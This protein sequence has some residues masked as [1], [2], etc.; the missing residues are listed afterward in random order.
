[1]LLQKIKADQLQ[2][3]KDRDAAKTSI[4]TTVIG[5][6]EG[7]SKS[8]KTLEDADVVALV[9]KFVKNLDEV[10]MMVDPGTS[11]FEGAKREREILMAYLPTQYSERELY[12]II[13]ALKGS[14]KN[15]GEVMGVLK[16]DHTGLYDGAMASKLAKQLFA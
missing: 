1:M 16:K 3:R 8:G 7:A 13:E 15:V 10:L 4:L 6:A 2:S 14:C 11:G 5:E 12:F 9:K